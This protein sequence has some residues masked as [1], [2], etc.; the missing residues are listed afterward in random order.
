MAD[1]VSLNTRGPLATP[2][3]SM[4]S[5]VKDPL[6]A[7]IHTRFEQKGLRIKPMYIH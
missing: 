2:V 1:E 3:L 5:L 7:L 6:Q 4:G